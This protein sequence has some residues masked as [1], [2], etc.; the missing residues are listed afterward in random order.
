MRWGKYSPTSHCLGPF[1][2]NY[3][4]RS[5]TDQTY[6]SVTKNSVKADMTS[7]NSNANAYHRTPPNSNETVQKHY[8]IRTPSAGNFPRNNFSRAL[9]YNDGDGDLPKT[10]G[11][12]RNNMTHNNEDEMMHAQDEQTDLIE[13]Y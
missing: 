4:C 2:V 9:Q 10:D 12:F 13:L 11:F 3:H 1:I 8:G 6:G 5:S 7:H